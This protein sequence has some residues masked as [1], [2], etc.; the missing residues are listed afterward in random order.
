MDHWLRFLLLM[1]SQHRSWMI[2]ALNR[3]IN[4]LAVVIL[5]LSTTTICNSNRSQEF[6]PRAYRINVLIPD[7][8]CLFVDM[9]RRKSSSNKS[10]VKQDSAKQ[11]A[12]RKSKAQVKIRNAELRA[13][14]D[15]ET[16]LLYQTVCRL[17]NRTRQIC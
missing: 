16:S 2:S 12:K 14:L 10:S 5:M 1:S 7:Y 4:T 8:L 9:P 11:A 15:N 6:I 3:N 13:V 17:P